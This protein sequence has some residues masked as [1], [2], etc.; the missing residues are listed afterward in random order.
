M[1]AEASLLSGKN[2]NRVAVRIK[3]ILQKQ[4]ER[5]V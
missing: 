4:I 2:R 5:Y 1:S 3:K